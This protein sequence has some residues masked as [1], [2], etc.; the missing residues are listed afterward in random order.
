MMTLQ[1]THKTLKKLKNPERPERTSDVAKG[2]LLDVLRQDRT[3][4]TRKEL[5]LMQL[6]LLAALSAY[7]DM[8]RDQA[9]LTV[10]KDHKSSTTL[11]TFCVPVRSVKH[12][13]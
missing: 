12:N 6:D 10:Q 8:E 4:L 1:L 2:R 7:L 3:S 11:L 13:R 5:A 9:Q